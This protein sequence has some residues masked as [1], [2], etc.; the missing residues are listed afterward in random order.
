MKGPDRL[1]DDMIRTATKH[2]R[3]DVMRMAPQSGRRLS[4]HATAV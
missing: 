2:Y 1:A 3:V 4:I